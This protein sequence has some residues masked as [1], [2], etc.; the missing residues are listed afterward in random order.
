MD[1][2]RESHFFLPA[3]IVIGYSAKRLLYRG[4]APPLCLE[5]YLGLFPDFLKGPRRDIRRTARDRCH[6]SVRVDVQVMPGIFSPFYQLEPCLGQL[7]YQFAPF[8]D[9]FI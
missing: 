3:L 2:D 5:V 6:A 4:G 9:F 7:S 1:N 8:H